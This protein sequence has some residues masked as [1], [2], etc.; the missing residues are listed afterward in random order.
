MVCPYLINKIVETNNKNT[1][2]DS[3]RTETSVF[4]KC[5]AYECPFYR[6]DNP[7]PHQ[8]ARADADAL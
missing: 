3:K 7:T 6:P 2:A 1:F 8:C 5:V 4:G